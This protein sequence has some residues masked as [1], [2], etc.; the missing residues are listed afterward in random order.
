LLV[1]LAL[2]LG[3][4]SINGSGISALYSILPFPVFAGGLY[5]TIWGALRIRADYLKYRNSRLA[6][7]AEI[8]ERFLKERMKSED[9]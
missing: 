4:P 3:F 7:I 6:A 1:S 5:L 8:K 9:H 2:F